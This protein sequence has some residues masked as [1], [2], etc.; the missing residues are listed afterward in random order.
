MH[1]ET[2]LIHAG[3]QKEKNGAVMQSI[4]LSTTF[5]RNEDGLTYP[6]DFVYSRIDNPNRQSLETKLAILENGAE[7][8]AFASG[9]AAAM[10]VFHSLKKGDH[11]IIPYDIYFGV[12][13]I[14]TNLY[15]QWNLEFSTVDMSDLKAV[16]S[17][18]KKNTKLIW[19]ES[20]SNPLVQVTDIQAI[21]KIAKSKSN[22]ITC[23]D[24]TWAT[25]F[26]T[27]PLDLGVDI[28]LHSTTKY[29]GGH[30]DILGGALVFK[31]QN[32]RSE[33]IRTYQKVSGAV[34]SPFDCWLLNR[35]LTTFH[36]R[37][38]VHAQ[39]AMLLAE[40]LEKNPNIE[41]VLY[42]GLKSDV[43]HKIA[44]KQMKNGFGGMMSI[45]VK[46]GQEK[47]LELCQKLQ[48]FTHAT[49]LG[50]VE[51]LIEHRRSIEGEN[52]QSPENLL[53]ISV[54]LENINDLIADFEQ[55]FL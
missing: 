13:S 7:A 54:G 40:Y 11:V 34:P 36:L 49:S 27:K 5:E 51:S 2:S 37:M 15:E 30:S 3:K 17:A 12:K 10:A 26:F 46:G 33:F 23:V 41:K 55:A 43:G 28:S 45:L 48:I 50:G 18:I 6:S 38:P 22:I 25:P 39:N 32:E 8:I 35:S 52:S 24:N 14:L 21:V 44:K 29:L 4:T 16:K 19:I 1:L 9:S 53:R 47:A 20:P 31:T 42:P